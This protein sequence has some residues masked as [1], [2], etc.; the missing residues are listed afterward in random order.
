MTEH[1]TST[2]GSIPARIMASRVSR[3]ALESKLRDGTGCFSGRAE[4]SNFDPC[5]SLPQVTERK[6]TTLRIRITVGVG[7]YFL[8]PC[9]PL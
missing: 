4:M 7:H 3:N 1:L 2:S 5:R 8:F 9:L 6:H